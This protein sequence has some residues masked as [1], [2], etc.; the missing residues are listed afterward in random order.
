MGKKKDDPYIWGTGR[1]KTAVA[2]VRIKDGNGK[3]MV[4]DRQLKEYFRTERE[5]RRAGEPLKV[6]ELDNTIDI[7]VT[8]HGGGYAAQADAISLGIARALVKRNPDHEH[9]LRESKYLT[10]DARK[11]ERKK[12]G[13]AGARKSFQFSKR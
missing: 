1:R 9:I 7:F 2:R 4:N 5:L 13:R 12:Y 3:F 6:L 10:R 11:K 8:T